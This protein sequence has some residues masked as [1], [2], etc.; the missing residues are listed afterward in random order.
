MGLDS[1]KPQDLVAHDAKLKAFG[2]AIRCYRCR[3]RCRRGE[4]YLNK[5]HQNPKVCWVFIVKFSGKEMKKKHMETFP[6]S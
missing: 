3:Q 6:Q 2:R 5:V 1:R 4:N